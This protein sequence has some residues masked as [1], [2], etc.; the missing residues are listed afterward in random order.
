[1]IFDLIK[2]EKQS[3]AT[4][5][6]KGVISTDAVDLQGEIIKQSGLDFEHFK[7]RGVFNYEHRP[8]AEN[9]LGYPTKVDTSN[10]QTS[11]EGIL[12]LDQPR[13]KEIYNLAKAM[14]RAGKVRKIGFSVEGQIVDRDPKD[15]SIVTK[16]K[17]LNCAITVNP[18]NPQ[19]AMSLVKSM[20][21]GQI[22][23]QTPGEGSADFSTL[24]NQQLTPLI[25]NASNESLK[26]PSIEH[27]IRV[28]FKMFPLVSADKLQSVA[29]H[30]QKEISQP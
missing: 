24:I 25:S 5:K 6:I 9:V 20:L 29:H 1:V 19:T 18:V 11:I 12:L 14:E 30:I 17:V 22:G 13:A 3:D 27:I 28:L 16:A 23:Y 26:K 21:K 7:T 15:P 8:G 2:A 4:A 10:D